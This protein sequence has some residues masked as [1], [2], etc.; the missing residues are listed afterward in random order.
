MNEAEIDGF[1]DLTQ[2]VILRDELV[3]TD[4]LKGGLGLGA[5]I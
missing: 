1:V 4:E 3:D 2:Q 5:F